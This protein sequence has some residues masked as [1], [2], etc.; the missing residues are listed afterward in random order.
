VLRATE[1]AGFIGAGLAGAAYVPQIWHL[2]RAHCSAGLSRLAFGTWLAASLLV[3]THA[4]AIGA[5]VFIALGAIQLAATALILVYT[6]KYE[7][8]YCASH[9]PLRLALERELV[10]TSSVY[11]GGNEQ[12]RLDP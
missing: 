7:H 5:T 8:S 11:D 3:T 1:L 12:P 2:I 10:G 9:L 4:V 6:T